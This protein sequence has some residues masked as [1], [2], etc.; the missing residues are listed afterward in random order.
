MQ[1]NSSNQKSADFRKHQTRKILIFLVLTFSLSS[2][3]ELLVLLLNPS[4]LGKEYYILGICWSP[5]IAAL[6][7]SNLY[8]KNLA[9]LGWNWGISRYHLWSYVTPLLYSLVAY[10]ATW[11]FGLGSFSNTNSLREIT[12]NF[13]GNTL[14]VKPIISL[15][16]AFSATF[17]VLQE[18][19]PALEDV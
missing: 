14:S 8:H 6:I 5:G 3:F 11:F 15:Y 4:S 16:L 19:L 1:A 7:T 12:K 17:G 9:E 10:L 2:I 13:A 18:C